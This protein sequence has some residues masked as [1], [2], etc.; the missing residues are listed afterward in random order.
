MMPC[1]CGCGCDLT[2]HRLLYDLL[3]G[4]TG[5]ASPSYSSAQ[6]IRNCS[7]ARRLPPPGPT[8]KNSRYEPNSHRPARTVRPQDETHTPFRMDFFDYTFYSVDGVYCRIGVSVHVTPRRA[9]PRPPPPSL[10]GVEWVSDS[11]APPESLPGC[12]LARMEV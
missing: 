7:V 3:I 2:S 6:S 5:G 9:A 1:G 12:F 10:R 11:E 4:G 8:P